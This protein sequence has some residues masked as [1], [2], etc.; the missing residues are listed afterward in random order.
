MQR[1]GIVANPGKPLSRSVLPQL[2]RWLGERGLEVRVE[3][4][5]ETALEEGRHLLCSG[6][7]LRSS[8]LIVALGGD[9]T[10]LKAAR[11]VGSSGIPIL[12]VN[13]GGLGF[14]TEVVLEELY[15]VLT[16][17]LEGEHFQVEPRM[18]LE[19][20]VE[21]GK[22]TFSALN[23]IVISMGGSGRMVGFTTWIDDEW[24][25]N[26]A[27]DGII[28]A[29]P[30]GSTAY[31][32]AANGPIVSPTMEAIV[33]NPICPHTLGLRPV[34]ISADK[35]VTIG[36]DLKRGGSALLISDG[37]QTFPLE[38]KT[39]IKVKKADHCI[40]LIKSPKRSFY[41]ILRAKL[42]WGGREEEVEE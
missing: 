36:I 4:D 24:V 37:Q 10:L 26:Y 39:R 2:I 12:G 25:S 9:G 20:S 5:A 3:K 17:V 34:V 29:T 38:A 23:D 1:I 33:V 6:E 42:S 31:S 11:I 41:E 14:L 22:K 40:H 7:E 19:A 13:L 8:E 15:P 28:V 16:T 32:L 27:A 18:V 35:V 30:T 21:P